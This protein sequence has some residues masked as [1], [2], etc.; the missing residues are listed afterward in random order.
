M[1]VVASCCRDAGTGKLVRVDGDKYKEM[2]E[3]NLFQSARDLRLGVWFKT[4]NMNMIEWHSQVQTSIRQSIESLARLES[5]CSPTASIQSLSNFSMRNRQKIS[6][7]R[8]A[9][10]IKSQWREFQVIT[11]QN[12]ETFKGVGG[13]TYARHCHL[14]NYYI[15]H[16]V[17]RLL[18]ECLQPNQ[19]SSL[20]HK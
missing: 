10:L 9:K 12:M 8:C 11:L 6:G 5:C 1:L 17:A 14:S 3:E 15:V 18:L 19:T 20:T 2:L 13:N 4:K 7:P 16:E